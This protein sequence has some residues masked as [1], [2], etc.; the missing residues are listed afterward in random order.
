MSRSKSFKLGL[1]LGPKTTQEMASIGITTRA[2]L[3]AE[4]WESAFRR[5]IAR[6][7]DRLNLNMA[8][9]LIGAISGKD[10]REIS[11]KQKESAK[12]LIKALKP[13]KPAKR[14]SEP[15]DTSFVQFLLDDQ[16]ADLKIK[17][18]RMFGCH[19][20][21]RDELFFGI[22][23]NGT[24]Y[25]KAE[26]ESRKKYLEQGMLAFQPS[27]KIRL[28][29]YYQVPVDIIEDFEELLKWVRESIRVAQG[30]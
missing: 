1:N 17:A 28:K 7:P 27:P 5:L 16:L 3:K 19:G 24:L 14:R 8:S 18:K 11:A 10:W 12:H 26:E 21:Y 30:R 4:G 15:V 13:K 20:L 25:L 29:N 6:Y 22:V 2:E 9:A 23:A